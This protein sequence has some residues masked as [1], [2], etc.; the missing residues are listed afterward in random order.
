MQWRATA[1][2]MILAAM[3]GGV[4]LPVT[5]QADVVRGT[6]GADVLSDTGRA[7][8]IRAKSG[9]DDIYVMSNRDRRRDRV[10]CGRGFDQ[11]FV[12][13][14]RDMRGHP[15]RRDSFRGCEQI[16]AYSP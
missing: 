5:A 10:L 1:G 3:L 13:Y 15:E 11:V 4:G 6:R 9:A 8:V 7:D 14:G 12:N 2:G 16:R